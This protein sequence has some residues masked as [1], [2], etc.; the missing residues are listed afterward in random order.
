MSFVNQNLVDEVN[1]APS[2]GS[3]KLFST[4][5]YTSWELSQAFTRTHQV[6]WLSFINLGH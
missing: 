4:I 6:L 2:I 1:V 5:S 3:S